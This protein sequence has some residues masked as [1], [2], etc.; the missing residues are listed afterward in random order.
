MKRLL[1]IIAA[2]TLLIPNISA[3]AEEN[4]HMEY[5]VSPYGSDNNAGTIDS[6]FKTLEKA[7]DTIRT[8]EK[9]NDIYIYLREGDYYMSE[10]FSLDS[11]DSGNSSGTVTYSAY[12]DESVTLHGD[13]ILDIND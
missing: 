10:S 11:Q 2:I 8:I 6:P 3:Y 7:R 4:S 9:N 12:N 13:V 5:F 1:C